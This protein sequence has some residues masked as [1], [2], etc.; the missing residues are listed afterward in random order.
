MMF[1]LIEELLKVLIRDL[2]KLSNKNYFPIIPN[3]DLLRDKDFENLL[4]LS[5]LSDVNTVYCNESGERVI[6]K[7]NNYGFRSSNLFEKTNMDKYKNTFWLLG[8][9]LYTRSMCK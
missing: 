3:A 9:F 4:P 8:R 2:E 1:I 6:Y 5:D 7:S